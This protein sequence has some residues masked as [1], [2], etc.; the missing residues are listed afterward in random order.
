MKDDAEKLSLLKEHLA[1]GLSQVERGEYSE[2]SV[3]EIAREV[4]AEG[5]GAP[6]A[7]CRWRA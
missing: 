4:I 6:P 2:R 1:E 7:R 5:R 3:S